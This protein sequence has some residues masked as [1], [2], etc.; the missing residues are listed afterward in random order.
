VT[1]TTSGE[2]FGFDAHG[3]GDV[4]GDGVPEMVVTA[5]KFGNARGRVYVIADHPVASFGTGL[6]G[7]GGLA[8]R[9]DFPAC[10]R[11]GEGIAFATSAVVGGASGVLVVGSR[12]IDRPI[13]GGILYPD[14]DLCRVHHMAGGTPGT[15]G[16]GTASLAFTLPVD[17]SLAGRSFYG[18]AIY[19][20]AGAL[21][22]FSFTAGLRL[23]LY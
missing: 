5:A 13:R 8:P 4:D 1:S 22:G 2:E 16:A 10:P 11:L 6:S 15:P 12:R 20:D 19:R 9:L 3:L 14:L 7:S 21:A 18:Q 17:P 23:T